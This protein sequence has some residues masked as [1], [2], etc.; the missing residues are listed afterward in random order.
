MIM[1]M[2]MKMTRLMTMKMVMVMMRHAA[3]TS[4]WQQVQALQQQSLPTELPLSLNSLILLSLMLIAAEK[5]PKKILKTYLPT[6]TLYKKHQL[7]SKTY[8]LKDSCH[9]GLAGALPKVLVT[10][11]T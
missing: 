7:M 5:S 6:G 9:L 3:A 2:S 1:M 4:E 10:C 8:Q 11:K